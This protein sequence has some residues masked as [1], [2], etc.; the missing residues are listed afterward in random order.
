MNLPR[1]QLFDNAI[2]RCSMG[3]RLLLKVALDVSVLDCIIVG[4]E[5]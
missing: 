2:G 4:G 1:C 3:E 5:S